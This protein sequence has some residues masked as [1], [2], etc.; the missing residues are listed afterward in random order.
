MRGSVGCVKPVEKLSLSAS[1]KRYWPCVI[2]VAGLPALLVIVGEYA[3]VPALVPVIFFG[4]GIG[5]IVIPYRLGRA[6]YSYVIAC[7][8]IYFFV[9]AALAYGVFRLLGIDGRPSP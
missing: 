2:L 5:G 3:G 9:G 4:V 7:C 8:L 1:L 6:P